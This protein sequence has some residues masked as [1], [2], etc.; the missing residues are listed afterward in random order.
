M[1]RRKCEGGCGRWLTSPDAVALGYGRICAERL[2]IPVDRPPRP[3]RPPRPATRTADV[4]PEVH[5]DQTALPLVEHQ[6]TLW[7]L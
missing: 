7:S 2:G 1:P 3:R 5:P 4:P 6:P